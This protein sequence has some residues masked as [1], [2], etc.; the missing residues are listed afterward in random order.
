MTDYGRARTCRGLA[1]KPNHHAP[2]NSLA[3]M[4]GVLAAEERNERDAYIEALF[5]AMWVNQRN[6]NEPEEPTATLTEAGLDAG[7]YAQSI[8]RPEIKEQLRKI[9]DDAIARDV[10]G[11]PTFFVDGRLFFGQDRLNFVRDVLLN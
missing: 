5:Q 9:T 4:R 7:A 10:F 6:L 1:Y 2:L 3:L 11:V 8:G